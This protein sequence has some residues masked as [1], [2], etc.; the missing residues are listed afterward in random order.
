MFH[1]L[2]PYKQCRCNF[3]LPSNL[4]L[5]L[6]QIYVVS[7]CI[8]ITCSYSHL[9]SSNYE[10]NLFSSTTSFFN[11]I[12]LQHYYSSTSLFL[13]IPIFFLL[14]FIII[15]CSSKTLHTKCSKSTYCTNSLPVRSVAS[16]RKSIHQMN[17]RICNHLNYEAQ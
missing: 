3:F 9:S 12:I 2:P 8:I 14:F 4:Q 15:L 17:C 5:F 11:I 13:H 10:R 7:Y 1:A 16:A 6:V